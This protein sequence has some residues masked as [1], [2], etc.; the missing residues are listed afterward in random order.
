M[1][2]GDGENVEIEFFR[3]EIVGQHIFAEV[4]ENHTT[5]PPLSP[6]TDTIHDACHAG[7][8]FVELEDTFDDIGGEQMLATGASGGPFGE[9]LSGAFHE[10]LFM[11]SEKRMRRLLRITLQSHHE[12]TGKPVGGEL[13]TERF[14]N[15]FGQEIEIVA[16]IETG[17]ALADAG[18]GGF[19]MSEWEI[20][21]ALDRAPGG[22]DAEGEI[23]FF[24]L[25]EEVGGKQA[26]PPDLVEDGFAD[27]CAGADEN[28][29][30]SGA[31]LGTVGK[32]DVEDGGGE[33]VVITEMADHLRNGAG[34]GESVVVEED[35]KFAAGLADGDIFGDWTAVLGEADEGGFGDVLGD[36]VRG[37]V[38][39]GVVDDED[40]ELGSR[41]AVGE[42]AVEAVDEG[43]ATVVSGDDETDEGRRHES[44]IGQLGHKTSEPQS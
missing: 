21:E 18:A 33:L 13:M 27:A 15:V 31:F 16:D 28:V 7:F 42:D 34:V 29:R 38:D 11:R 12:V 25:H 14:G 43:R 24:G 44:F 20:P 4:C 35:D 32:R 17:G 26:A 2:V 19:E 30:I 10:A 9:A 39:G 6:P 22:E 37:A 40:F 5:P 36:E 3:G 8:D 23:V 1:V 41:E